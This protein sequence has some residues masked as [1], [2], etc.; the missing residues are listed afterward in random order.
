VV[1]TAYSYGCGGGWITASGTAVAVGIVA[2]NAL[3]LG[4]TIHIVSGPF[5]G[6]VETV[7]DRIGWGS[8]LDFWLPSCWEARQYGRQ[9]IEIEVG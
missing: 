8:E 3:P 5:A 7:M 6:A 2:M 4:S 1:S 9:W